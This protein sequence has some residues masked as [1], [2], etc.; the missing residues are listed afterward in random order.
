MA[1][2]SSI[3]ECSTERTPARAARLMPSLPWACTATSRPLAAAASTAARSSS[4]V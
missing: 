4:S 3:E 2:S 1:S